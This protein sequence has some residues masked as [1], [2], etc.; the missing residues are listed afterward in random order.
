M[1]RE[2]LL[3]WLESQGER[4]FRADQMLKWLY[5]RLA[6]DFDQMTD[7][8]KDFRILLARHFTIG[9]LAVDQVRTA[10]DG[11]RKFLFRLADGQTIESVLMPER[12]HD[13]LCVSSQVGCALGCRFCL[14]GQGGLV[15]NLT[16]AEIIGQVWE[17]RKQMADPARLTNLVFMG[18]GEPLANY[19][20]LVQAITVLTDSDWG[21]K[22]ASRRVTVS[23]AGIVPRILDLGRDTR[24][25]LAVSLNEVDDT[26]RSRL[27][28]VNRTYPLA[29]LLDACRHYPLPKGRKITFEYILFN[30]L[31]DTPD[32]A[33]ALARLLGPLK[34]KINLIP[35][36]PH[37]GSPFERPSEA[38][39]QAFQSL[40]IDKHFTS[41]VRYSKG[42]DIMAA[43][44]QLRVAAREQAV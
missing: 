31:N 24:V 5:L 43:C 30:N 17:V 15:R 44:G 1:D 19:D 8:S 25:N 42:L 3:A 14:T 10:V 11:T 20:A 38:R 41:V 6:D 13:T 35:F 26:A 27:M 16:P 7:L 34:A 12:S 28:P 2:A 36:N 22:F 23:T 40:L 9:R 39:I 37:P 4:P 21:M 33:R 29:Q 18:M 32:H